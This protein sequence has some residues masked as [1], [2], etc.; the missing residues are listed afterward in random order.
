MLELDNASG[1][2]IAELR[3][4][5]FDFPHGLAVLD[6]STVLLSATYANLLYDVDLA[7]FTVTRRVKTHQRLVHMV[8]VRPGAAEAA[9]ANTGSNS[10]TILDTQNATVKAVIAVGKEP[11]GI[12]YTPDGKQLVV[13]E[14]GDNTVRILDADDFETLGRDRLG[15]LP[16]RV[17]ITPDGHQA[18]VPNPESGDLSLNVLSRGRN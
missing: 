5:S 10:I 15:H 9:I 11:E 17:C 4:D 18:L 8:E 7:S 1:E 16:V 14:Q 6:A 13:A 12:A 3:D 2:V